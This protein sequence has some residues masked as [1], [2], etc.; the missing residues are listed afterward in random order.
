MR[1]WCTLAESLLPSLGRS[2]S[3]WKPPLKSCD[4][5]ERGSDN[6][7]LYEGYY[8]KCSGT[9]S[10][11]NQKPHCSTKSLSDAI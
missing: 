6:W 5:G 4:A 2:L 10:N 9:N 3:L 1:P 7:D 11:T 8:E